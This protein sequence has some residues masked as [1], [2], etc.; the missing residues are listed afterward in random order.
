[1]PATKL[2]HQPGTA[3]SASSTGLSA[4][5]AAVLDCVDIA[6]SLAD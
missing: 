4:G 6:S 1:M 3:R 5:S 2:S